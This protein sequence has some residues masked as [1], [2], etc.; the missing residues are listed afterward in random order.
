[1]T[2]SPCTMITS[3]LIS[4]NA[5]E[6][7]CQLLVSAIWLFIHDPNRFNRFFVFFPLVCWWCSWRKCWTKG[8]VSLKLWL[9]ILS[10]I[11]SYYSY[12]LMLLIWY[13]IEKLPVVQYV[14][15]TIHSSNLVCLLQT[16]PL[17]SSP[18]NWLTTSK[19]HQ[20][21]LG[22]AQSICRSVLLI[23]L[24][25]SLSCFCFPRRRSVDTMREWS[26]P[27]LI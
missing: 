7:K 4:R 11:V 23:P 13:S 1:M 2:R 8:S 12:H 22:N 17:W 20:N 18:L 6:W 15:S 26:K 14:H 24:L 21:H 5:Y 10:L 27:K 25:D 19:C 9:V 16:L 3:V